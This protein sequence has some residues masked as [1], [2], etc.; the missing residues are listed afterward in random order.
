MNTPVLFDPPAPD[1][2]EMERLLRVCLKYM[3]HPEVME[4]RFAIGSRYIANQI[5]SALKMEDGNV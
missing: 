2:R 1:A 4:I 3:E 5:R